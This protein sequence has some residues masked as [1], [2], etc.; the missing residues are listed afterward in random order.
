MQVPQQ[1]IDL[2]FLETDYTT[3]QHTRELHSGYIQKCT[4][5]DN[6]QDAAEH[7]NLENMKWLRDNGYHWG[8]STFYHATNMVI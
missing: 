7:G 4:K 5:Y 6:H 3:L 2:I 8:E 1:L